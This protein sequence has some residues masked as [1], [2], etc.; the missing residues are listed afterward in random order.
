M[1]EN[2]PLGDLQGAR[3]A[4]ESLFYFFSLEMQFPHFQTH[5]SSMWN[6]VRA[7][8]VCGVGGG[9]SAGR[10][11]GAAWGIVKALNE[12]RPGWKS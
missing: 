9:C 6:N 12:Q 11:H 2:H 1:L 10:V 4:D 3:R 7:L 5:H 8:S